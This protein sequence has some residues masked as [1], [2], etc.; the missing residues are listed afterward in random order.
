[1]AIYCC[2]DKRSVED[3]DIVIRVVLFAT[4]PRQPP[5]VLL[6]GSPGTTIFMNRIDCRNRDRSPA[7]AALRGSAYAAISRSTRLSVFDGAST[8]SDEW[9]RSEAGP[10]SQ[11]DGFSLSTED[12][13][14]ECPDRCP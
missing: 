3:R 9:G 1:M 7:A 5:L 2:C 6:E 10:A 8:N 14:L 4:E 13:D 11:V 12:Y